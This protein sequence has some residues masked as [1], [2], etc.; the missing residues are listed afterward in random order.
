MGN[1][2]TEPLTSEELARFQEQ[3]FL[4]PIRV[5][6][7]EQVAELREAL[8]DHLSG[9]I[10]SETFELTDPTRVRRV[11]GARGQATYEYDIGKMS[12]PHT[13]PF[14]F[15]LWKRDERFRKVAADPVIAGLARQLLGSK[16][17]VLLED[18]V[19]IKNPQTKTLPWH[20]DYA[21]WPLA[22]PSAVTIWIALDRISHENGTMQVAPGSHK[23]GE[24]LP[25]RFGDASSYMKEH[26]PGV[27]EVTQEPE[28]AG[29]EVVAYDLQPGECGFHDAMIWHAS[30][31]NTTSNKRRAFVLRYA[32]GGTIWVG[33]ERFPYDEVG[34]AVGDPIGGPHFP[35][36]E[37]A[38]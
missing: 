22:T 9:R 26:R 21:Y 14:L 33:N 37:T 31:P 23:L 36:I 6:S 19:V 34:V 20:Q 24:R 29:H 35:T 32:A 17:V 27:V 10:A 28:A 16:E 8:E 30:T 12:K 4:C 2:R 11:E 38:F 18:N 15:N 13:F 25:V 7:D 5:L 3:G 1:V